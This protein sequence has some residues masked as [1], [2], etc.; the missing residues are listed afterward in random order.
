M[1]IL[2][3]ILLFESENWHFNSEICYLTSKTLFDLKID[4]WILN[5]YFGILN[6][7]SI[8]RLSVLLIL[9]FICHIVFVIV[10]SWHCF[11]CCRFIVLFILLWVHHVA[12]VVVNLSHYLCC[13]WF[14]MLL[15]LLLIHHNVGATVNSLCC[16]FWY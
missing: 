10:G 4:I 13:C 14:V 8:T 3:W 1:D 15:V 5:Y 16:W 11:C 12:F 7:Y 9:L 2:F 6:L